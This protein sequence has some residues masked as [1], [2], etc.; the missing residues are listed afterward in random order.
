MA[1]GVQSGASY[2][3][4]GTAYAKH[5]GRPKTPKVSCDHSLGNF[6]LA[7]YEYG[8]AKLVAANKKTK[9]NTPTILLFLFDYFHR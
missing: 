1:I 5:T 8:V 9:M 4:G 3:A 6:W 7:W 2:R